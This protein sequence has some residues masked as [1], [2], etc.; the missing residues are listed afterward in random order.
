[1]RKDIARSERRDNRTSLISPWIDDLFEPTRWFE[2]FFSR[3]TDI[4]ET[5]EEF[6]VKADL[7]G[8]KKRRHLHPSLRK[9]TFNF[10]GEKKRKQRGEVLQQLQKDF[11]ATAGNRCRKN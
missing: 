7:P 1:M 8:V 11:F 9:P 2:D 5:A 6:V 10:G 3:S 4:E